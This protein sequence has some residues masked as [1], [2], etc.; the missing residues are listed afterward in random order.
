MSAHAPL[1]PSSAKRW[2][3]CPGSVQATRG[4]PESPSSSFA[5]EGTHAHAL[6]ARCLLQGAPADVVCTDSN[7]L[8][9]LALALELA[10]QILNGRAFMV[11]TR[12]RPL[13]GLPEVWGTSDLVGFS[14]AGPVDRILVRRRPPG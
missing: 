12:L 3:A 10:R 11:E 5:D 2:I 14:K 7:L 6:F 9:P 1:A 4:A 13:P 8:R